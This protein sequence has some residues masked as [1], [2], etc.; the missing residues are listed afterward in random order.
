MILI[1]AATYAEVEPLVKGISPQMG[2]VTPIS[3]NLLV[4]ITGVGAVPTAFYLTRALQEFPDAF[5]INVGVAGAY[6]NHLQIGD[7][8]VVQRDTFADYGA[9]NRGE[10]I[11]MFSMGLV[12]PNEFPYKQ[13]WMYCDY[14]ERFDIPQVTAITL[15]KASGS[16][17]VIDELAAVYSPQIE[18]ME[19]AAV[20]FTC[21]HMQIPF[22]CLRSISNRVEPRNRDNWNI[23]L[24]VD[25]L[26]IAAQNIIKNFK[27]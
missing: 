11:S 23:P 18:T 8:A 1:V 14:A 2:V 6:P 24:A 22:V 20:F 7:V 12:R 10:F 5:V 27:F 26:G 15:A 17:D 9:D 3:T 25:R 13:G 21:M 16:Q 4:L 19:G